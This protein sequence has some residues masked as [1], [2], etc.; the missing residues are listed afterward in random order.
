MQKIV[1]SANEA[2]QRMDK[3]LGKYLSAAP[4]SF[5]YKMLRKKN[6]T[7]NGKKA[8][9]NE[10]LSVGDE[11][12]M[13][14]A[15]ETIEKF[16]GN[17]K[18]TENEMKRVAKKSTAA[19]SVLYEDEHVLLLDKPS[20]VLS[21]KA[22]PDDISINEQ[23][24]AYL[25][26]NGTLKPEELRSFKPAICN[27]LDRNTSG[28]VAAGK[29]LAGLQQLSELFRDRTMNKF[30]LTIVNGVVNK[31]E[32]IKGFLKKD[33]RTNKVTISS[34]K[35]DD[36]YQEIETAYHPLAT[37][38]E[39]TL[40]EV[41]LITGR[42]HQ[43]RAHMASKGHP[44]LGDYKYGNASK[45]AYFKKK[46]QLDSQI[47]HSYRM[48]FSENMDGALTKLS[49]KKIIAPIPKKMK[50]IMKGEHLKWEHGTPEA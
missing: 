13:F 22:R 46:Y 41:H 30:Y 50:S 44:I 32:Y 10:M 33:E 9:G 23:M 4:K 19:I 31:D 49:G 47:L 8:Q 21:Q 7:L 16:A 38:G 20:G 26:D 35:V 6:I 28:I 5:L 45:N 48:E 25:M 18:Q 24:I 15:D 3:L 11:I 29:T 37:N 12:S 27:R 39:I 36:D 43:I 42:T 17:T 40:L 34:K 1:V 14:L 2:G